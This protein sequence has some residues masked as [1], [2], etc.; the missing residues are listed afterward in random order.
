MKKSEAPSLLATN[1]RVVLAFFHS[2]SR[3]FREAG[4]QRR[5]LLS[6]HLLRFFWTNST[7]THY[8]CVPEDGEWRGF[9]RGCHQSSRPREYPCYSITRLNKRLRSYFVPELLKTHKSDLPVQVILNKTDL[10]CELTKRTVANFIKSHFPSSQVV[11]AGKGA[12]SQGGNSAFKSIIK[13]LTNDQRITSG[14][15]NFFKK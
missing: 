15:F 8:F 11:V 2:Q 4:G 3:L 9:R 12:K 5:S 7:S 6:H 10:E 1:G 14:F 13:S